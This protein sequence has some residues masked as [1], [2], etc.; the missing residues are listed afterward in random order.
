MPYT[1]ASP[2]A[3]VA[4]LADALDSKSSGGNT[5]WVR[6]PPPALTFSLGKEKVRQKKPILSFGLGPPFLSSF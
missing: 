1:F 5:V 2:S 6:F 4:K 3:G